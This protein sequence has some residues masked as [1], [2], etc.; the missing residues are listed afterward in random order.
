MIPGPVGSQLYHRFFNNSYSCGEPANRPLATIR[1]SFRS[2]MMHG[3]LTSFPH[4]WQHLEG[5]QIHSFLLVESRRLPIAGK[6][7]T[8]K[9]SAINL[10]MAQARS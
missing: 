2:G 4:V 10:G 5:T 3:M 7:I 9:A 1:Q 8:R 6:T